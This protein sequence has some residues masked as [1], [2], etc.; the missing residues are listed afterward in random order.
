MHN[1]Y[2]FLKRF[3]KELHDLLVGK[4]LYDCFSQV[5]EELVVAFTSSEEE[6]FLKTYISNNFAINT[7][8]ERFQKAKKN[9]RPFFKELIG[10][11]V[12]KVRQFENERAFSIEFK[13]SKYKVVFKM[14]GNR[15][16][17][18]LFGG[19]DVKGLFKKNL[20]P[21]NGLKYSEFDRSLDF[22]FEKFSEVKGELREFIP[23]L[24]KQVTKYLSAK[25]IDELPLLEQYENIKHLKE[26]LQFSE[27]YINLEKGKPELSFFKGEEVKWEGDHPF[28]VLRELE[29]YWFNTY[30]FAHEKAV[31]IRLETKKVKKI[32]RDL[33]KM[34][35]KLLEIEQGQNKRE[36]ADII[37]ANL[38]FFSKHF[39][40]QKVFDFYQNKEIEI[41]IPYGK[42]P[43]DYAGRLYKKAKN[44]HLEI[45]NLTT[46]IQTKQSELSR[47]NQIIDQITNLSTWKELRKSQPVKLLKQKVVAGPVFKEYEFAGFKIYVGRNSKNNDELTLKFAKKD[48]LWLHAKDVA[49]SHVVIKKKSDQNFPKDVIEYAAVLA[50]KNSKRKTDSLCPV[51]VTPKK[52]VRKVKGA[53]AGS[54]IVEREEV[55]LVKL[56]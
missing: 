54:V 31:L 6:V 30:L 27:C 28:D 7:V 18:L 35:V 19:E 22:S 14:Y 12:L 25:G 50:G 45:A 48:D 53:P 41:D 47:L 23:T 9:V 37:M 15:S 43:Q 17:V 51:S 33:K 5:K 36:L 56:F 24:G 26:L 11:E 55:L 16:N 21:D 42:T 1:N 39:P 44:Q 8:K 34:K 4:V 29:Y 3:S 46:N 52:F 32:N 10:L 40:K 13:Q 38:H 20:E 49:G 2:Y